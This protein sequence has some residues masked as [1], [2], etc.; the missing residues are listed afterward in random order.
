[1]ALP[2]TKPGRAAPPVRERFLAISAEIAHAGTPSFS[3]SE[4]LDLL[5]ELSPEDFSRAVAGPPN[6]TFDDY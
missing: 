5:D 2:L 1:M 4:M 6:V 3:F